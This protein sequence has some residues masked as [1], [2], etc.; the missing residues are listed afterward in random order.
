M[1]QEDRE[2]LLEGWIEAIEGFKHFSTPPSHD[3]VIIS[4]TV[5]KVGEKASAEIIQFKPKK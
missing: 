5:H 4:E 2:K 3:E 1:N